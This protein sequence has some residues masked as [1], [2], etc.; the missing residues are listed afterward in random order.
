MR[1][2]IIAETPDDYETWIAGQRDGPAVSLAA[3]GEAGTL[4]GE[5]YGCTNCHTSENSSISTY[6][7]NLTHLASRTTFASGYYELDRKNLVDWILDAP[8]LIPMQ[9]ED[10]RQPPPATCVGMPSFTRNTPKGLPTMTRPQAETLADY[11]LSLS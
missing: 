4:F 10:C 7:P 1:F 6:G 8:S 5:T 11:L 2:R 3:A 9:S